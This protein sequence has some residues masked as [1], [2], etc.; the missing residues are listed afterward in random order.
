MSNWR[1]VYEINH[2]CRLRT[3]YNVKNWP[4][5]WI[6][7]KKLQRKKPEKILAL[8][9]SNPWPLRYIS[10]VV[11]IY[12]LFH[13]LYV[14]LFLS[15]ENMNSQLTSLPMCG[16]NSSVG[17]ASRRY[18][19]GHGFDPVEAK[20]FSGFFL[21]NFFCNSLRGSFFHVKMSK[22]AMESCSVYE[23]VNVL[24]RR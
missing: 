13:K 14:I 8:T 17:G 23:R 21:C 22:L 15:R 2:I 18:R 19:G 3:R 10:S 9:G 20:F 7:L 12:D 6:Q 1:K 4:W 5:Q 24:W 11:H 16:F